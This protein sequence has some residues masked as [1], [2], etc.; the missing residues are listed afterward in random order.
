[1]GTTLTLPFPPTTNHLFATVGRRRIRSAK[2]RA[3]S[4]L[5]GFQM[6][7]QRPTP[8]KGPVLLHYEFQEG[9][10]KRKRDIGN[11]EKAVTDLLVEHGVI[12]ADDGSI[13]REIRLCWSPEVTGVRVGIMEAA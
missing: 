13:V 11:L 2:Y 1:V 9:Q 6:N 12:E 10:D 7:R 3:W 4:E 5:A 8:I